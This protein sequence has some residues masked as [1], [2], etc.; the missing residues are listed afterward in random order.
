MT[1][2]RIRDLFANDVERPIEEVIKVDQTDEDIIKF[3]IDEY[4]VT[5]SIAAH[6][7]SILDIFNETPNKPR[8][9]VGVWVSGFFGSGKSSFA[10]MLGLALENRP[11]AGTPAGE[12]FATRTNTKVQVLL[13][14][15]AEKI[16]VH[17]VIFDVSTDRGI[18]SG[19]QTLTEIMYRLLLG[20]LGYAKDLD[21]AEL[22]IGLEADGRL[23]EFKATFRDLT[24]REW[25]ERKDLV[26][27]SLGEA[28]AAMRRLDPAIY[29]DNDSW[30]D[31][32]KGKADIN[33]GT[34]AERATDLIARRKPGHTLVFVV[35]EVGQFVARD[36]QKMLDLQAIV[37][38]LGVKGRGKHWLVVTSQEKLN[39]LTAG[40]DDRKVELARL[41]DRFPQQV[42]LEPSD[43]SEVTSKRVLAKNASAQQELGDL[44]E[45]HRGQLASCTKLSADITLPEL[46]RAA[47]IDLYPLLPYQIDLIIQVVSG[48]RTQGG[49]SKHVGGANRTIIKLAQQLLIHPEVGLANRAVGDLVRLDEIYD[50]V[51]SNIDGEIRTK[52]RRIPEQVA[53]PLAGGVAKSVCLLQFVQSV[54]RTAENIAACL[55]STLGE[56]SELEWVKDALQELEHANLVRKGDGGYRIPT[57]AEDDWERIRSGTSPQAS[58][59]KRIHRG[60][61]NGFWKPQPTFT[62]DGVKPF[63]AGLAV[64]GHDEEKGDLTVHIMLAEEGQA[65]SDLEQEL[66]ARSQQDVDAIFWAVPLTDA[67]DR[68]TVEL[69]RSREMEAKKGRDSR[70]A[71]LSRLLAEEKSRGTRHQQELQRLLRTACLSGSAYFRGNDRSPGSDAGDVAKATT[72]MLNQVL[73]DVFPRFGDGAAKAN[74]A[75]RGLD[76]L[77]SATDLQGLPSVF[78]SLDLLRDEGG[79]TVIDTEHAGP[80]RDVFATIEEGANQGRKATGKALT[81]DF[82]AAPYGWDFEVVRLFVASLMRAGKIQMTH[83]GDAIDDPNSVAGKDGLGNNNHFKAASFQPRKGIDFEAVVTAN[84]NFQATFGAEVKELNESA[85]A[86]AI[87]AAV[88]GCR[89]DVQAARDLLATNRLPGID[90]LDDALSEARAIMRGTQGD[91]ILTF[92]SSHEKLKDG[93]KRAAELNQ[94][95]PTDAVA[96]IERA[97]RVVMTQWPFLA[98]EPDLAFEIRDA[99]DK[100]RDYLDQELFF[101]ELAGIDSAR[102]AIEREHDRRFGEALAA[103][104]EAY[105]EALAK[106]FEMSDWPALDDGTK[107]DV[108]APLQ[109]H[110]NDDG[111]AGPPIP[112]LR[113]DRD[114]C[115]GRLNEAMQKVNQVVEGDRMVE[116]TIEPFF[117]GGV[118]DLEQLE[119]ALKG[120]REECERYIAADK[121]IFVR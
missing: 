121:K 101:R 84:Q 18:R 62:L 24:D 120:L 106:L 83:K 91:A 9:G 37:Q 114:A 7:A 57:P 113:A 27:F 50:L 94:C 12:R 93:I 55:Y 20:S 70:T 33:P 44:Y 6:Y 77:T 82:G 53:H 68:E 74:E 80:L 47:F 63:R 28:S 115:A 42:H 65:F 104:V 78:S 46:S 23:D 76:A 86:G 49:A 29:Q 48:L 21:L 66:R 88:E 35:D 43:I 32:A 85:V 34:L 81:E 105:G 38:Q 8:D 31:A 58:D 15:I 19:N 1:A 108:A 72:T 52:I 99:A 3:E 102:N 90:V 111:S 17:A 59:A 95:L 14:Q 103:K 98:D 110:A 39:E 87:R 36:V 100:L 54:H 92:N 45:Q 25:D 30:A 26:A 119:A 16:P 112:Q 118:A 116:I 96:S 109:H 71:D 4:V 51:E 67:I 22:E 79:K 69:F 97:R 40:L 89:D 107:A 75:R 61:L 10:K 56:P 11:I 117:R 60:V 64:D 2:S 5:D 73:P 13:Q 41:M